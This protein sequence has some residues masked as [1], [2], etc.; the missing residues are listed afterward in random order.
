MAREDRHLSISPDRGQTMPKSG[1]EALLS[2]GKPEEIRAFAAKGGGDVFRPKANAH[3]HLPPNFS[4]FANVAEAVELAASQGLGILGASNYYHFGVYSDFAALSR[5]R[6]IFPLF[7]LE[8]VCMVE[9]LS[10]R[11]IRVNDPANPGKM[12]LCGKA[13]TR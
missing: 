12:Y 9:D 11:G 2:L 4:A 6:N 8:I 7:G 3:I 10:R 13:I 5:G 1:A